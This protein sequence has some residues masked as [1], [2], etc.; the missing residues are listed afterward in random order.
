[1]IKP[2]HYNEV[3]ATSRNTDQGEQQGQIRILREHVDLKRKC[4]YIPKSL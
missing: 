4:S 3:V 1:M 2:K